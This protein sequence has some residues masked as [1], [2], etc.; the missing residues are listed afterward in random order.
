MTTEQLTIST[1]YVGPRPFG[2]SEKD[3]ER[4]FGRERD[5]DAILS[6]LY[7]QPVTL[8]CAA[9]GA[10]KTSVF[11]AGV[12]PH[13]QARG[14]QVFPV[15]R[16]GG[17]PAAELGTRSVHEVRNVYMHNAL[18]TLAPER[19]PSVLKDMALKQFLAGWAR[20]LENHRGRP[21]LR[22]VAF[23][24]FEELFTLYR[25]GPQRERAAFFRQVYQALAA[26]R[27]LRVVFLMRE[28]YLAQLEPFAGLLPPDL[29]DYFRLE[30]LDADAALRA[31][32]GPLDKTTPARRYGEG[33]AEA[34]VKDLR[35]I[36]RK[37]ASGRAT[38]FLGPYVEP[39]QLQ[40]VCEL[41]WLHLPPDAT[42]ITME[43]L[44]RFGNVKRAL[45]R[46]YERAIDKAV[47][48]GDVDERTLR[49]WFDEE[50]ITP[51]RT[52][53]TVYSDGQRVGRIPIRVVELLEDNHILHVQHRAELPWYELAHDSWINPI[54][55]ANQRWR[56]AINNPL[57]EPARVWADQQQPENLLRGQRL[58]E[59]A[60]WADKHGSELNS[61]ER[62]FLAASQREAEQRRREKQHA[63]ELQRLV[64]ELTAEQRILEALEVIASANESLS[65]NPERSLLLAL[66]AM[67]AANAVRG[68]VIP[69]AEQ[70][71]RR[72]VQGLRIKR[73]LVHRGKVRA[74]AVSPDARR[75]ATTSEDGTVGIWDMVTGQRLL[76]LTGQQLTFAIAYSRD[77]TQLAT[78]CTDG[79]A[80]IWQVATGEQTR[81][82]EHRGRVFGVDFSADGRLVT[83]CG[84]GMAR[85]WN[86]GSGE[87]LLA[88]DYGSV[89]YDVAFSPDG[90]LLAAAG[91]KRVA[92]VWDAASGERVLTLAGHSYN[93]EC[94]AFSPDGRQIATGSQDLTAKIW[95]ASSGDQLGTLS[96]H[97][98]TVSA[99]AFSPDSA[100][101]ATGSLDSAVKVWDW[102]S[103]Q[104][105]DTLRGHHDWVTGVAFGR[106]GHTLAT[107]GW[108]GTARIWEV[109]YG[110]ETVTLTH[111]KQQVLAVAFTPDSNWVAAA[112]SGGAVRIA[113]SESGLPV[114][115]LFG[116]VGSVQAISFSPDGTRLATAGGDWN[117]KVWDAASGRELQTLAGHVGPVTGIGWSPDGRT[118]A[119]GGLD[120][121]VKLWDVES[122]KPPRTIT[123]AGM[124]NDLALSQDG[125]HLAT[126]AHDGSAEVWDLHGSG[127]PLVLR[128]HERQVTAVGFSPDGTRLATGSDDRLVKVWDV[129]S[130]ERVAELEGHSSTVSALAFSPD[131]SLL[132]TASWDSTARLWDLRTHKQLLTLTGH[133]DKLQG[134]AFSPDG[135]Q[136]ATVSDDG[137]TRLHL[138][139]VDDLIGLARRRVTRGLEPDECHDW[140]QRSDPD[141]P[142]CPDEIKAAGLFVAARGEAEEG[143]LDEAAATLEEAFRLDPSLGADA[144][145]AA[146]ARRLAAAAQLD[147]ARDSV[148]REDAGAVATALRAAGELDPS[149]NLDSDGDSRRM[150]A[151]FLVN[152]ARWLAYGQDLEAA[153]GKLRAAT[154]LWADWS[155]DAGTEVRRVAAMAQ[156]S[157]GAE[158]APDGAIEE[159]LAA[160]RRAEE[161]QPGLDVPASVFNNLCWFGS[162]YGFAARV[163]A[164]G[165]RAV[166]LF[167]HPYT[168]DSRGLARALNGDLQGAIEDFRAFVEWQQPGARDQ[169]EIER[170]RQ[171]I[172]VLQA[173]ENPF[174]EEVLAE[175]RRE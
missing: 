40:G 119:T 81:Q 174:S 43:H 146:G 65:E 32:T 24:Q 156:V 124:I 147:S 86:P 96:G 33:V 70:A 138:V 78:A 139:R 165:D 132:A 162:L 57:T 125:R 92:K 105:L 29:T 89:V 102:R 46:L 90:R 172:A 9:S 94:V 41:L 168:R 3:M 76:T 143:R 164:V 140:L 48:T 26:D 42:T 104:L 127:Q 44:R 59:A 153:A 2:R 11:N 137:T 148:A 80:R 113:E 63:A 160:Y 91:E 13:L 10:G 23:D 88:V 126:A 19:E 112:E 95:D 25:S 99:V 135:R 97:A 34:L 18:M 145:A 73:R 61:L 14:V 36:G 77:G 154:R 123:A 151:S 152:E 49:E 82:L 134:L 28:E 157:R 128:G 98:G 20:E 121:T 7:A 171:W 87:Q 144:D 71:L 60:R 106:D 39:M 93:V 21:Q 50:L 115:T 52:R 169:P 122:T 149:L 6:R 56:A 141:Q 69:K 68:T 110:R 5:I 1:P 47:G 150:V 163:Q 37:D 136:L 58:K 35:K 118:V 53:G 170:R 84:D 79:T 101:L 166:Q 114:A 66:Y 17:V 175:L 103:R 62:R 108:D 74:L 100:L 30:P 158:L 131:G 83:A 16:V 167:P 85:I 173:G 54:L 142:D 8:V 159:A 116:H 75:L 67:T 4:F 38:T 12:T 55:E 22:V 161:L 15:A 51:V 45:V 117:A 120:Q 111:G 133:T 155:F 72:T 64:D 31:I 129:Q 27:D 109:P 130:G 107:A